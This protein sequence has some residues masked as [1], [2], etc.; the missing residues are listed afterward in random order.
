MARPGQWE[1]TFGCPDQILVVQMKFQKYHRCHSKNTL[2]TVF[3]KVL[4]VYF[5]AD[6]VN[7]ISVERYLNLWP[8]QNKW[9]IKIGGPEVKSGGH[10][11]TV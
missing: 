3:S 5:F 8:V 6:H 4:I 9:N 2:I 10:G 1:P 11:P 7:K